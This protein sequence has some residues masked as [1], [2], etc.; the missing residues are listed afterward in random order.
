MRMMQICAP[1]VYL[2]CFSLLPVVESVRVS[3]RRLSRLV[4]QRC[5]VAPAITRAFFFVNVGLLYNKR[6]LNQTQ[7]QDAQFH[8]GARSKMMHDI[9]MVLF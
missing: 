9:A 2:Y 8:A 1:V 4:C 3:L 7:Q 6:L 5:F